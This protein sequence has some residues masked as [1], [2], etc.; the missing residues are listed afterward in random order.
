MT[1]L[2]HETPGK[3]M[4]MLGTALFSMALLFAVTATD[5][6][7]KGTSVAI[8]SYDIFGPK[9]VVAVID[10]SASAYSQFLAANLFNPA[11]QSY[12]LAADNLAYIG[13]NAAEPIVAMLNLDGFLTQ[14]QDYGVAQ[15]Q[16]AG[17]HVEAINSH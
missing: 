7:F 5:S 12:G 17:A 13:D 6:S 8:D 9:N 1:F 15:P 11:E 3:V 4:G 14:I 2:T 16:V 10:N